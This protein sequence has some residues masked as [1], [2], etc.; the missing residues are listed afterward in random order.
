M[1]F[2][3][4]NQDLEDRSTLNQT[5]TN[6]NEQEMFDS[7]FYTEFMENNKLFFEQIGFKDISDDP[8]FSL[9][10]EVQMK[11]DSNMKECEICQ[12]DISRIFSKN[13]FW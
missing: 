7:K 5:M 1:N 10:E 11:I 2:R 9:K 3:N 13:K 8:I 4:S 12:K 6:S